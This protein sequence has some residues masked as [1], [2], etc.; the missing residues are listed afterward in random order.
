MSISAPKK[1]RV[2]IENKVREVISQALDVEPETI[3]M[4]SRFTKDLNADS[5]AIVE[6]IMALEE[7]FSIEVEDEAAEQL[8]TVGA[9]VDYLSNMLSKST[10]Q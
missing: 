9:V 5:L 1:E 3:L 10:E 6:L 2:I 8:T 4:E 7:A